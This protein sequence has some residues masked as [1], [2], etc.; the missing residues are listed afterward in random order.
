MS[1][2]SSNLHALRKAAGLSKKTLAI[3]LGTS[4]QSVD[5]WEKGVLIPRDELKVRI[6]TMYNIPI[7]L[8]FYKKQC[9]SDDYINNVRRMF[10]AKKQKNKN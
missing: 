6:S 5:S 8:L 1:A 4:E 3:L 2:T 9:L 10:S 7:D